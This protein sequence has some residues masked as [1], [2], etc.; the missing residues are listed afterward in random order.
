M[1]L[2]LLLFISVLLIGAL[3]GI[4]FLIIKLIKHRFI[5]LFF[6]LIYGIGFFV[7]SIYAMKNYYSISNM[8]AS[9]V[10]FSLKNGATA[11]LHFIPTETGHYS[12]GLKF[13]N[14]QEISAMESC[15]ALAFNK[16]YDS[17]KLSETDLKTL[18]ECK[19]RVPYKTTLSVNGVKSSYIENYLYVN[20]KQVYDF[21]TLLFNHEDTYDL[22]YFEF[23]KGNDYLIK[24]TINNDL[25]KIVK[26]EPMLTVSPRDAL[27]TWINYFV[28]FYLPFACFFVGM[29]IFCLK[30]L[31]QR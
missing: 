18:E 1:E 4:T 25:A 11:Q 28:V 7:I 20:G 30:R 26:S 9:E 27:L 2:I 12:I 21:S 16:M 29:V 24:L 22:G 19:D 14:Q 17:S 13:L 6:L 31:K 3:L 23:Q 15:S 8:N 10:A 5:Y